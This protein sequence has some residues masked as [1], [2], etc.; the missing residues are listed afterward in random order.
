M[1]VPALVTRF[2]SSMFPSESAGAVPSPLS[3]TGIPEEGSSNP[4]KPHKAKKKKKKKDKKHKHKHKHDKE[5]REG[6]VDRPLAV[7]SGIILGHPLSSDA[8]NA[9]SPATHN[10]P[11]SPEYEV[12]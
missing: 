6:D 10:A 1:S 7:S 5:R 8:S 12:I 11:S 4:G 9:N 3:S 2:D